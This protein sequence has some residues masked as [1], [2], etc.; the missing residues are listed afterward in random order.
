[1]LIP[2]GRPLADQMIDAPWRLVALGVSAVARPAIQLWAAGV[3][4]VSW[5]WQSAGPNAAVGVP[6]P[7]AMSYPAP[8][9]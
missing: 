2:A 6:R 4:S 5:S 9:L 8:A 1:M 7:E 3:A